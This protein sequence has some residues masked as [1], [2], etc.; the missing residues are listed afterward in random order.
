M[1]NNKY[2][3]RQ[4]LIVLLLTILLSFRLSAQNIASTIELKGVKSSDNCRIF[5]VKLTGESEE[6][7]VPIAG[8]KVDFLTVSEGQSVQ[9]GTETTNQDGIASLKTD[10]GVTYL[11]DKEGT[12]EVKATFTGSGKL[13]GSEATL[14][15]KELNLAVS[16]AEKDSLNTV[17]V[18]ASTIGPNGETIPLKETN[19]NIYVQGLYSKLKVGECFVDAGEGTFTFPGNI[20]GDENGNLQIFVRLEEN[21]VYGEIEKMEQAKW[22]NHRSGFMEPTR[23]L[24]TSGAPIW[25]ITTLVILLAGVWSHYIYAILQM[26]RIRKEGKELEKAEE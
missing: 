8:A 9:L 26:V 13:T 23:S 2:I 19:F 14:K 15:F 20:P 11:K 7:V 6:G 12:S 22:G 5:N 10:K 25:M 4:S 3:F 1:N 24:W 18:H 21:E 16:L 17:L